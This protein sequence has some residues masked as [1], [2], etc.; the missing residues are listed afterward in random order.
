LDITLIKT[1]FDDAETA[2]DK[3]L[4]EYTNGNYEKSVNWLEYAIPIYEKVVDRIDITLEMEVKTSRTSIYLIPTL[5][6]PEKLF[7]LAVQYLKDKN[8]A[9]IC[10]PIT[11]IRRLVMMSLI[12]WPGIIILIIVLVIVAFIVYRKKIKQARI[13]TLERI[14]KRL[15][16]IP[17]SEEQQT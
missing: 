3:A 11:G 8:Y 7:D 14:R 13:L 17:T 12:F 2:Y 5:L 1:I 6:N 4:E 16:K 9:E 15:E 10:E